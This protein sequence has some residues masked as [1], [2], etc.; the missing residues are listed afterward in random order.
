[1]QQGREAGRG[2]AAVA[3]AP[4]DG[5]GSSRD[6]RGSSGKSGGG[7]SAPVPGAWKQYSKKKALGRQAEATL[8][9][10]YTRTEWPSDEAVSSLWDLHRLPREKVVEWFVQRRR[11][12]SGAQA[13]AAA[14]AAPHGARRRQRPRRQHGR[15]AA[16]DGLGR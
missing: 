1:M 14:A 13:A 7:Y 8:E 16:A 5:A 3:A 9:M 2:Q 4:T 12:T 15:G 10:I 11:Q 6:S